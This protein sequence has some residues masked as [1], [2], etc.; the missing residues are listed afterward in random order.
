[1]AA[2]FVHRLFVILQ[3]GPIH[4]N[5]CNTRHNLLCR[6]LCFWNKP[7]MFFLIL[8]HLFHQWAQIYLAGKLN[9]TYLHGMINDGPLAAMVLHNQAFSV[10]CAVR[11][12]EKLTT[13]Q[14]WKDNTYV[15]KEYEI[16]I[17]HF[18][19]SF[20]YLTL[21]HRAMCLNQQDMNLNQICAETLRIEN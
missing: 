7:S 8:N 9:A 19:F 20:M 12:V 14:D 2:T 16:R 6:W 11:I 3:L 18:A 1:M 5:S 21:Y 13:H 4:F 10:I 15:N 17:L